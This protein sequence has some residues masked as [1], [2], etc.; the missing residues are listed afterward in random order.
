MIKISKGR[1]TEGMRWV[2]EKQK[3]KEERKVARRWL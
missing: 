1:N 3:K 2:G